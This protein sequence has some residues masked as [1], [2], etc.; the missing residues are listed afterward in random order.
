MTADRGGGVK[1]REVVRGQLKPL[2]VRPTKPTVADPTRTGNSSLA[3]RVRAAIESEIVDG[4]LKPG[5]KLDEA[6]ISERLSVSRTPVREALRGLA[7][8]GLVSFQPRRGAIVASPTVGEVINLFE[9]VAELE[10]F[11]ARLAVER[12]D[13]ESERL[14]IDAHDRCREAA[15]GFDPMRYYAKNGVFHRA[16]HNGARNEMLSIEIE[17]LDKRLSPY[18]RFITFRTGRTK[19]ALREHEAIV[20]AIQARDGPGAALAMSDHVRLLGEDTLAL[21]KSLRF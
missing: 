9:L 15:Q 16:I 4:R 2:K 17:S 11:A 8:V 20:E 12:I 3:V 10:G 6:Q 1:V 21:A 14:I 7:A 19:T 5:T 18:R 13:A